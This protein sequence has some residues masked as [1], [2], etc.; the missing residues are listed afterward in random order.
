MIL[1]VNSLSINSSSREEM[2]D[3][4][5]DVEAFVSSRGDGAVLLFPQHTTCGLT[6]NENADST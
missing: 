3:I 4:T 2:I 5:R 6:I 1:S